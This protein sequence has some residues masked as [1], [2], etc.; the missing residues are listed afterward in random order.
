[1]GSFETAISEKIYDLEYKF[2]GLTSKLDEMEV[3]GIVPTQAPITVMKR[4]TLDVTPAAAADEPSLVSL[5]EVP[6]GKPKLSF[7]FSEISSFC[8]GKPKSYSFFAFRSLF[9]FKCWYLV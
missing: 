6:K 7:L 4:D 2:G 5:Y 9:M 8:T 3:S 1:M